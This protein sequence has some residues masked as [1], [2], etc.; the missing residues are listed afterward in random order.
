MPKR[1]GESHWRLTRIRG[2]R[3]RDIVADV[4]GML[5]IVAACLA[6]YAI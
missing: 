3:I 5:A 2:M 6:V 4:I 1:N